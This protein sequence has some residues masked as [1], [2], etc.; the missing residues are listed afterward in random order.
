MSTVRHCCPQSDHQIRVSISLM[1]PVIRTSARGKSRGSAQMRGVAHD[2]FSRLPLSRSDLT[3]G[4]ALLRAQCLASQKASS[5]FVD[6]MNPAGT[7]PIFDVYFHLC[8]SRR[9]SYQASRPASYSHSLGGPFQS[10]RQ[11][12]AI[13]MYYPCSTV[14]LAWC[15][16]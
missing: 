11:H 6:R 10:R 4:F 3:L 2:T 13:Y 8:R 14:L 15:V 7:A 12:K 16:E 9:L 1:K 5:T